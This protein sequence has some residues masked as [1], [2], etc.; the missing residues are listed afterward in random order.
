MTLT[1]IKGKANIS[2]TAVMV[3]GVKSDSWLC[4]PEAICHEHGSLTVTYGFLMHWVE[5]II[6]RECYIYI[7]RLHIL[8]QPRSV[9]EHVITLCKGFMILPYVCTASINFINFISLVINYFISLVI[10]DFRIK[11]IYP[12]KKHF[13]W[14]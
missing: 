5:G 7:T 13:Y 11:C 2:L 4:L 3:H 14:F 9:S 1:Q 10:N 8:P 12:F 6:Y